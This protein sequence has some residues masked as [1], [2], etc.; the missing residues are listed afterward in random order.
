MLDIITDYYWKKASIRFIEILI[1]Q[2]S[3]IS[4]HSNL[5]HTRKNKC[6]LHLK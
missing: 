2:M 4:L 1:A 6:P 3:L 5:M